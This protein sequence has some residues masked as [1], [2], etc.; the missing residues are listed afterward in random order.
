MLNGPAVLRLR[1]GLNYEPDLFFVRS[2]QRHGIG[3]EFFAGIPA[4][5][6]EVLSEGTRTHDLRTK[7]A[8][9][10]THGVL[11]YWVIDAAR[12][13]LVRHVAPAESQL[14]FRLTEQAEGRLESVA[15]PGFWIDVAWLW[16]D[17]LPNTLDCLQQILA[18]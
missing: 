17:P 16:Q 1:P 7:A 11:E 4:L 5:I 2:D 18:A 12:R 3:E 10:R 15:V 9:Y 14:P 13:I 8:A 6:V